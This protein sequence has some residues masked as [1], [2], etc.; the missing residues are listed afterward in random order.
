MLQ[1]LLLLSCFH[2]F[3]QCANHQ[4]YNER[5]NKNWIKSVINVPYGNTDP[6][7]RAVLISAPAI[8]ASLDPVLNGKYKL[9]KINTACEQAENRHEQVVYNRSYQRCESSPNNHTNSKVHPY[10]AFESKSFKIVQKSLSCS[11]LLDTF[12]WECVNN[13]TNHKGKMKRC[14]EFSM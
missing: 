5:Q 14:Q 13:S 9:L 2:Y 1:Q 11:L 10:V 8:N 3:S 4:E 7:A 6:T 12:N